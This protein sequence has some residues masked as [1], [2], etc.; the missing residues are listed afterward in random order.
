[1]ESK[2]HGF[3]KTQTASEK[4]TVHQETAE[5]SHKSI[6]WK[7]VTNDYGFASPYFMQV[8]TGNKSFQTN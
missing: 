5:F 7:L 4:E 2:Y 1:M 8:K 6:Q 3:S